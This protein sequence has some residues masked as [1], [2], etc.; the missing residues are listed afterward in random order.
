MGH[1]AR[2]IAFARALREAGSA[3]EFVVRPIGMRA[4]QAIEAAGFSCTILPADP[5][6]TD[7]ALSQS[8]ARETARVA[9]EWH[10][11]L[12]IVDHYGAA[13]AYF[14]VLKENVAAVGAIDD[15]GGR[16][17]A[18][19]DWILNGSIGAGAAMYPAN[20]AR[21]LAGPAFALL[22]PAFAARR[23]TLERRFTASDANVLVTFGGGDTAALISEIL[24]R[25]E[26]I[27]RPLS[28]RCLFAADATVRAPAIPTTRHTVIIERNR[29]DVENAMAWADLS[30]NAGG[31]TCWELATLGVPMIVFTLAENQRYN[32][33]SLAASGAAVAIGDFAPPALGRLSASVQ[34]LLGDAKRREHMSAIGRD[35]VDGLGARRAAA[36]VL[37]MRSAA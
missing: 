29:A 23:A 27:A 21:L 2:S 28:L 4:P 3:I 14:S 30:I 24:D 26:S 15:F 35:L 34:E 22:Q 9:H 8:D 1:V 7:G 11:D 16:D 36:E 37:G 25:C 13:G 19:I 10:A 12:V 18:G 31:T 6:S 33:Q 20:P 17:L 32:A 5:S